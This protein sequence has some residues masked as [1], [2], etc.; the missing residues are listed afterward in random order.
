MHNYESTH[1]TFPP[2]CLSF[3]NLSWNCFVLPYLEQKSLAR[4]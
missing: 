4:D 1:G 3:N 2:G